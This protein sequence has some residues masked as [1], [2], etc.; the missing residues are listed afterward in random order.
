M[1]MAECIDRNASGKIQVAFAVGG[2]QPSALAPLESEI[3]PR[4]SRQ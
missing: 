2:R 3:D 1:G 4:I